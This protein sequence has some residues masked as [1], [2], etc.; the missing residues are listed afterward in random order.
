MQVPAIKAWNCTRCGGAVAS[1]EVEKVVHRHH[2]DV[3]AL[4]GYWDV[5]DAAV[6]LFRGTNSA[7]LHN[8]IADL[9][10]LTQPYSRLPLPGADLAS[11]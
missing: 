1:F 2:W 5:L 3:T 9:D 4:V 11:S 10:I 7:D 6:V 8:W